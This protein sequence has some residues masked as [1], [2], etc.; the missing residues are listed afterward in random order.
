MME[1]K[2]ML[3][4]KLCLLFIE[5]PD[6]RLTQIISES[7]FEEKDIRVQTYEFIE[8]QLDDVSN[9][10]TEIQ[11]IIFESRLR[12]FIQDIDQNGHRSAFFISFLKHFRGDL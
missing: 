9:T 2:A 1:L 10:R 8:T 11:K 4:N 6:E 7:Y 5:Q 12:C 3:Q